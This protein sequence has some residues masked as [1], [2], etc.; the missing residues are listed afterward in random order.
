MSKVIVLAS[1]G[2]DSA[3]VMAK[4]LKQGDD[5]YPLFGNY[6]QIPYKGER[7][8]ID[9]LVEWLRDRTADYSQFAFDI[10][11]K[12]IYPGVLH[13]IVEARISTGIGEIAACPGRVL[14]FVGAACIW[15]FT[16]DWHEG[17]IAIGIHR[18]DKDRDSCRVGYQ[19]S[20]NETV[21]SLTQDRM[22]IIT[23]LMGMTREQMA[24]EVEDLGI[25]WDTLYNCYWGEPCGS[26][27]EHMDYRCPGCRRKQ[28]AMRHVGRP[29][30]EWKIPNRYFS[31]VSTR[32][33]ARRDWKYA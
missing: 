6:D 9:S 14:S 3:L 28:E 24:E 10:K 32:A 15:A 27:S 23:P 7:R 26:Q 25:P 2:V 19:D 17:Q 33:I 4:L 12:E 22:G 13:E 1:G 18:G 31:T 29:E 30:S 16:N 21:K 20:L 5:V 11:A 8:A